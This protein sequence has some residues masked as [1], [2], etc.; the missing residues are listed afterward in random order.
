MRHSLQLQLDRLASDRWA[1]RGVR[2]LLRATALALGLVCL[3]LGV[4]LLTGQPL[5]WTLIGAAALAC[6]ALGAVMVLRPRM[7]A[8]EVARRLDRRFQLHEQLT[9]ALEVGPQAEGAGAYL[10]DQA[11]RTLAQIRRRVAAG[12][13]FPWS[14]L[15]L[16]TSLTVL[17]GGMT[18]LATIETDRLTT[19]V[20]PLPGLNRPPDLVERFPQEPFQPPPDD[21][22]ANDQATTLAPSPSDAAALAA[23]AD[24]LRDQSLTRPA[25]EALDQGDAA[26]AARQL[27][28]EKLVEPS[29]A[30]LDR[31]EQGLRVGLHH[32]AI[33]RVGAGKTS[34][35]PTLRRALARGL[36]SQLP[37]NALPVRLPKPRPCLL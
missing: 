33:C 36:L 37:R 11:R 21:R 27:R 29:A 16:V 22:G 34:D 24:A 5:R 3:A 7:R 20:E 1:R 12:P 4:H 32:P 25:A 17:L 6:I 35:F 31:Q 13:R 26:G 18:T 9:T 28:D 10:Y 19:P 2:V 8:V 23:L 14:E 30:L 15:A